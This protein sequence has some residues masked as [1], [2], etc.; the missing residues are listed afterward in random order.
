MPSA[1][2][3]V[4]L[5]LCLTVSGCSG[6]GPDDAVAA[7]GSAGAGSAGLPD[8]GGQGG[9]VTGNT[10]TL[11]GPR[12]TLD[13]V[14][15]EPGLVQLVSMDGG[16]PEQSFKVV[17]T[18]SDGSKVPVANAAFSLDSPAFGAI[19]ASSGKFVAT[20]VAG[21]ETQV[22]V[23]VPGVAGAVLSA[24]ATVR[25]RLTRV[26]LGAGI[27]VDDV[28][29][30]SAPAVADAQVNI[31]YPLEG[32]LMPQNVFPPDIQWLTGNENDV[33]ELILEKPNAL[34]RAVVAH[35]GAAFNNHYIPDIVGFRALAQTDPAAAVKVQLKRWDAATK[36]VV[37]SPTVSFSF[38][39]AA[40][41]GSVY[42]WDI[43]AGRIQRIDDGSNVAVSLMPTPSQNC[44]GCHSVSPS[45]RY[46]AGRLGGGDNF[47]TTFDLT[48][49]LTGPAPPSVFSTSLTKWWFSS[50]SPDETRMVVARG[51][52]AGPSLAVIDPM[53]GR[54][55]SIAGVLP[56]NATQPAWS[57]DGQEIAYVAEGNQWGNDATAGDIAVLP[58]PGPDQVGAMQRI[59]AG[60]TLAAATPGGEADSYPSYAPDSKTIT[61]THG[62]GSRSDT[63]DGALYLMGRNGDNVVRL[64]RACGGTS[65]K[66][67]FQSRFSPFD[68]GEHFWIS[69]LSRRDY[70]NS[71]AGTRGANRQQ[72]WVAA[73]R[74]NAKPGADPSEVGYWLPGQK[75]SSKNI[76]A[77]W[78][79]RPCRKDGEG[80]SVGSECCGG[81]CR[82]DDAGALVCSPPA[83]EECRRQGQTCS[84]AS[85]CCDG[86]PCTNNVCTLPIILQ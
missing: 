70:G 76:S 74:K 44:V 42:Y 63:H 3:R 52:P 41:T 61:F 10:G 21:G 66:D 64:D 22:R 77:Y 71:A 34:L 69:F 67:N 46:M 53:T 33:F 43:A 62:T 80:C 28:D 31:V 15:I 78:A 79:P 75:T 32:A 68:T 56:A 51:N 7:G 11:S 57:P 30:F 26:V 35:T 38:A 83:P 18:M 5:V 39:R 48:T 82:P 16:R 25:V 13:S 1:A 65:T 81:D 60:D 37:E 24:E 20:G 14:A 47:G 36:V 50:W 55:V 4:A 59:H 17:G 8:G 6:A 9:E 54:D 40:L 23:E 19:S 45:G 29:K 58:V 73:I 72:I 49:D 12:A 84:T 86:L 2:S 85:D 27:T